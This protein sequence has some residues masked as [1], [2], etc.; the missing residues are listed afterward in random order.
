MYTRFFFILEHQEHHARI[1]RYM[2]PELLTRK[3]LKG[4]EDIS[5]SQS[6][7]TYVLFESLN[8]R[9]VFPSSHHTYTGTR[10]VV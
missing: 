5:Y 10:L 3:A 1:Y 8:S 6:I 7:D 2:A 9:Y 4:V